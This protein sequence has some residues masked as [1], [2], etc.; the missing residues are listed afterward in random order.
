MSTELAPDQKP[1]H[2]RPT[3]KK[4]IAEFR[5]HRLL[6]SAGILMTFASTLLVIAAPYVLGRATDLVF[7]GFLQSRMQAGQSRQDVIDALTAS[8]A[9]TQAAMLSAIDVVP[10]AGMD[11]AGIGRLL[12]IVL[13]LNTAAELLSFW[14]GWL[15]VDVVQ[16]VMYRLRERVEEKIHRLPLRYVDRQSR[17][18]L[19]SRLNNDL[20]NVSMVLNQNVQQLFINIVTLFGVLGIMFWM[21]WQLALVALATIPLTALIVGLV[22]VRSQREFG[23]QWKA[24]GELNSLM[25]ESIHGQQLLEVYGAVPAAVRSFESKN[26]QVYRASRKAQ[27]LGGSMFPAMQFVSNLVFVGIAI[28]GAVRVA[29]GGMTLGAV[30]AFIQYS[31]QF[32]QPLAQL[33][34]MIAQVQS[35]AASLERVYEILDA[36][37]E[38]AD[39]SAHP[40]FAV[41]QGD[42]VF[43]H[44]H[45]SYEPGTELIKDLNLHAQPGQTVAIV[46]HTGA[47][48]TTLVNLLLRFYDV[49]GGEIR[50][51]GV[52]IRDLSRAQVRSRIGMVL[53]D[54]WLFEGTIYENIAYGR[55]GA[56]RDEVMAAAQAAFVDHFVQQ[57][58]DGYDTV[59]TETGDNI[60]AGQRQLITI[61]RAF[62]ADPHILVLD[63]ATSN[64]DTRTE[65]QVQEAMNT[66]REGRTAFVIAHR[67]STIRNAH[68][69]VVMDQGRIVEQGTH[70]QLLAAGGA[71]AQ[72]HA[73]SLAGAEL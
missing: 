46:G 63:E 72:L 44:V 61:A 4:L 52:P 58:P 59:I 55:A 35:A 18:D 12:L 31:R 51:D 43:D 64:V 23:T 11:F 21:S 54:T 24:T 57:L 47:G 66:L 1:K 50:L 37:E 3:V 48:K 70:A 56:A 34:G 33:G 65:V 49:T 19:L 20:D 25:D 60:S 40:D 15:F 42:V 22:G 36:A 29:G 6:M 2:L 13:L 32:S 45:F 10:G 67:L 5:A 16:R 30:Q 68:T 8:G 26:A 17:G 62:V 7:I 71:Y 9:T 69:I 27:L 39:A 53:Q 28:L 14:G 38:P 73:A 41:T